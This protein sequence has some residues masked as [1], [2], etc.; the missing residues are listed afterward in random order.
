MESSTSGRF[1]SIAEKEKEKSC[2][3]KEKEP[4]RRL[5]SKLLE[6]TQAA[7]N[8]ETEL[9]L[10]GLKNVDSKEYTQL[11]YAAKGKLRVRFVD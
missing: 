1:R 8:M 4:G 3:K 10:V 6:L 9:T 5:D 2:A 11:R 7:G